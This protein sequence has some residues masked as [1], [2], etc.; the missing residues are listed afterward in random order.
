MKKILGISIIVLGVISGF[1]FFNAGLKLA[2]TGKNLTE[3]RSVGGTSVAEGY[4]QS[5]GEFGI[6][7]STICYAF[8]LSIIV[9]SLGLGGRFLFENETTLLNSMNQENVESN[10]RLIPCPGCNN[11]CSPKAESCPKCGGTI[12]N[13]GNLPNFLKT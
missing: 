5:V 6:A 12:S 2:S 1:L 11:L 3:L 9:I 8:G 4:Y 13:E 10:I 7:Y